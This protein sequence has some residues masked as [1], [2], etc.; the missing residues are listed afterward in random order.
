VLG[1]LLVLGLLLVL[2]ALIAAAQAALY[3]VNRARLRYSVESGARRGGAV[4]HA[5]E[6]PA[7]ALGALTVLSTV[8]LLGLAAVSLFLLLQLAAGD[9]LAPVLGA[10][11]LVL[12]T[13]TLQLLARVIG[14]ARPEATALAVY[15]PLAL[16]GALLAPLLL[17]YRALEQGLLRLLGAARPNDPHNAESEILMLVEAG[18]EAGGLEQEEREMIHGIFELSEVTAREV[19]VP[20]IDVVALPSGALVGQALD[21]VV[22]SGHSR[23]PVYE[24]SID[25]IIGVLY[26]KDLL[27]H[28][29]TGTL[30]D[31]VLPL[32]RPAH[33]VPEAKKVDEVL[34]DLQQRRVHI[35]IVVDEYGGTAGL[36]T[37]ED[38]LEEIVGEIRDEYDQAEE[39]RIERISER[40]AIL[41]ARVGIREVNDLLSLQLP[42]DE[43][44]TISGLVY[45]RLGKVP[46]GDDEVRVDGCTIQV[47]STEGRRIKKVRLVVGDQA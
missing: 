17:P 11:G 29:K 3:H 20:R 40:E 39:A 28:L 12:A 15:R 5:L 41:D 6:Q 31:P 45:D 36:L 19:M 24:G 9:L 43:F 34:Q 23:L 25:N 7:S 10:C 22:D 16:L 38:L 27:K 8:A 30:E 35:A 44:D 1:A 14:T 33:F 46:E 42:D 13:L 37:I 21:Q 32:V 26:A 4:L 47:I 18:D 2:V